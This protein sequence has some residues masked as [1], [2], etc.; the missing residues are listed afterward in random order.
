MKK[1]EITTKTSI[2]VSGEQFNSEKEEITVTL[3]AQTLVVR[4]MR[5]NKIMTKELPNVPLTIV[6]EGN[7]TNLTVQ[8][9]SNIAVAGNVHSLR[10]TNGNVHVEG[11]VGGVHTQ[12]G[13]IKIRGKISGAVNSNTGNIS[14]V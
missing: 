11:N 7:A 2:I 6:I 8:E 10:T 9:E 1:T 12:T 4:N 13:D 14:T 3:T 5:T